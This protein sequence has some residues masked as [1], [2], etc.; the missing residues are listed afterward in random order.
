M[1]NMCCF[2]SHLIAQG[3]G[4]MKGKKMGCIPNNM[5]KYISFSLGSQ[6]FL[7][8]YQLVGTSLGTLVSNLAKTGDTYSHALKRHF[9]KEVIPMLLRKGVYPYS[10][11]SNVERF[12]EMVL[13]PPEAFHNDLTNEPISSHDYDHA[14][15]IW[16]MFYM[17]TDRRLS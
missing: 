4:K 9:S 5:E 6:I 11:T 7:D 17:K 2:N 13:L 14:K 12:G 10:Y 16:N 3:L 15:A 1:H 8:S